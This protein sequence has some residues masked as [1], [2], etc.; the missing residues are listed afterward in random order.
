MPYHSEHHAFPQVPFYALGK[1]H[2]LLNKASVEKTGCNPSGKEGYWS[3]N[4]GILK[5]ILK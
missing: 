5:N 3:V 1:V 4:M 2:T